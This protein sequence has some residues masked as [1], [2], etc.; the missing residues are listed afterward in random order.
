MPYLPAVTIDLLFMLA[1]LAFGE[2]VYDKSFYMQLL[3]E[4][5]PNPIN[6]LLK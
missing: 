6:K 1:K 4:L 3:L 5:D 2:D